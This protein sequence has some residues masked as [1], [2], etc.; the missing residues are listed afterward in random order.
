M[1]SLKQNDSLKQ[2]Q[3]Q[4]IKFRFIILQNANSEKLNADDFCPEFMQNCRFVRKPLNFTKLK[5]L[6]VN[7]NHK[8]H[9]A[10][11]DNT[12][13]FHSGGHLNFLIAE[14]VDINRILIRRLLNK[15]WPS[16]TVLEAEDGVK[17]AEIAI[18]K[19]PD[20]ILMDIQ[21]PELNGFDAYERIKA[22]L[23]KDKLMPVIA[24]TASATDEIKA[25]ANEIGMDD[26]AI[27]PVT[28]DSLKTL[29]VKIFTKCGKSF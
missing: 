15:L 13:D 28:M 11:K 5:A 14:D 10:D 17:A 8:M 21:M 1:N 22:N 27:K 25:K 2:L 6:V 29:I 20:L 19:I 26:I 18:E 3:A 7:L 24:L 16:A 4:K 23:P 9:T 12:S